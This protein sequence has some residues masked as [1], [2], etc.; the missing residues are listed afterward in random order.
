MCNDW[1]NMCQ[2]SMYVSSNPLGSPGPKIGRRLV[3]RPIFASSYLVAGL[4]K[5]GGAAAKNSPVDCFSARGKVPQPGPC[6]VFVTDLS[7]EHSTFCF[8]MVCRRCGCFFFSSHADASAGRCSGLG[9]SGRYSTATPWRV[10]ALWFSCARSS[11]TKAA[12]L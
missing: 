5:G 10:S 6:R 11:S 3:R 1:Q 9:F 8:F 4:E 2:L 7:Y 12:S